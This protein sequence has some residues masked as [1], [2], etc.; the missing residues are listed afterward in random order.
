[1]TARERLFALEQFGIKLGLDNI[2]T[3]VEALGRPDRSYP[4]IHIA[5]TNGKGSVTAMV[6][7]GLRAAGHR[8]GRYTSPHLLAI[9]ERIAI[10]GSPIST[11]A[12]DE[13][14]TDVMTLADDLV[15]RGALPHIPTFFE[16]TTAIAFEA[17]KRARVSTAVIE[18]GLGGRFDATNV[19][20]PVIT[21]ITSIALDHER[22]LGHT[23]A[24]IAFEKAGIIKRGTP[25]ILGPMAKR[26][27]EVIANVA[28]T[29]DAP[30]L[31]ARPR[32]RGEPIALA[33]DGK[34]QHANAAVAVETLRHPVVRT[35]AGR[36]LGHAHV[37][38]ALTEVE[39]PARLEW[40]RVP[41]RGDLL[42]DAAHNPSG[43]QALCDYVLSNTGPLPML[44]GVMRD[45]AVDE[46]VNAVAPAVS[47]FITTA[48]ASPRAL[49]AQDL[50]A[51]I[52]ALHSTI[53][54]TVYDDGMIAV[55]ELFRERER[56]MVAGS[57][58]LIGPLRARLLALGAMPVRYPSKASPFYLS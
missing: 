25:V 18:V 2:T 16:T 33:L 19:I 38:S 54:C 51:R 3:I 50:A 42:I 27:R 36:A 14:T 55:D 1:M 29:L 17:F 44:I 47:R 9:E 11:A 12:F 58:F 41:G 24:D 45:K 34:H 23:P 52:E 26:P 53:P 6:E 56:A 31:D 40:L 35:P 21:A 28:R 22:H 8:T 10:A 39:W 49:P 48:V 15:R 32:E 4:T 5:G 30:F 13:V 46:I 20:A 57:I 43:A 37:V 7:R